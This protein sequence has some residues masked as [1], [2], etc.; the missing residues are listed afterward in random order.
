[1]RVAIAFAAAVSLA[2]GAAAWAKPPPHHQHKRHHRPV[3]AAAHVSYAQSA[4]SAAKRAS[5]AH[6]EEASGAPSRPG[7]FKS[8]GREGY[9]VSHSGAET[10]VGLYTRPSE[11]DLPGPKIYHEEPR[12]AAGLSVSL[13]L[14]H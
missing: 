6:S 2:A 9:G 11:P 8:D 10:M 12:G 3:A 1:M 5:Y 7:W 13:K 14:G 4:R